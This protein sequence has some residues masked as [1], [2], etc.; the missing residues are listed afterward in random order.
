MEEV[1][2]QLTVIGAGPGGYVAAL[3]AAR[4]GIRTV[5]VDLEA[6]RLGGVC[7]NW[8]CV[9][10][11]SLLHTVRAADMAARHRDQ[12]LVVQGSV[13]VDLGAAVDRSKK[14]IATLRKGIAF[15]LKRA[16]VDTRFGRAR[17]LGAGRVEIEGQGVVVSDH[18][19]LASGG[20]PRELGFAAFDGER[21]LNTTHALDLGIPPRSAA[22]I[23]AGASGMELGFLWAACGAKV[24]VIEILD[25]VLPF[26]D[27]EAA[28][29]VAK[30]CRKRG[31][32]VLTSTEVASLERSVSGV[33]IQWDRNGKGGEIEV[34]KVLVAAGTRP[35]VEDL[36]EPS[37]KIEVEKGFVK[38]DGH[39][40]TSLPGVYAVGD[41]RG[42]P[43]LAH[44][45]SW[46]ACRAV[47]HLAGRDA[48]P[49]EEAAMPSVVYF[50]PQVA[51]V[52]MMEKEASEKGVDAAVGRFAFAGTSMA[53]AQD[54]TE[55]FVKIVADRKTDRIVG[56][57]IVGHEAGELI[58]EM[59]LAVTLGLKTGDLHR[60][61]HPHPTLTE[62]IHE[63]ALDVHG[64]AVHK[65]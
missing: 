29:A 33:R 62:A 41:L 30:A 8:G 45:A 16:K 9:P 5:L 43:L 44:A 2:T 4:L 60:A 40:L 59:S 13:S 65:V 37:L 47:D 32:E 25:Q 51:Q 7:L 49:H 34:E 20:R 46:E 42:P 63:A 39:M 1:K 26:M 6:D 56:A 12:G 38:T 58:G 15:L 10:T 28:R 31:M 23:G 24:T 50:S 36:W 21:I 18:V 64:L 35:N 55:G 14:V 54:E 48:D 61:V 11:K 22:V 27:A 3:R 57:V 52:G 53:V 19:I 17:L